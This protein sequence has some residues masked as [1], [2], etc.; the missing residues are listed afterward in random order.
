MTDALPQP[1]LPRRSSEGAKAGWTP[2]RR[3]R[4]SAL[5]RALQ[6]WRRSTGPRTDTGKARSAQNALK[7]GRRANANIARL[8]RIR[9]ALR[10]AARNL[11][12]LNLLL[13]A[14][15]AA[16]AQNAARQSPLLGVQVAPLRAGSNTRSVARPHVGADRRRRR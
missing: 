2:E 12:H 13:R 15:R 4:Q 10:L 16:Y 8:L 6:P 1:G 9:A 11:A 3:A 7:H 14:R 5:L